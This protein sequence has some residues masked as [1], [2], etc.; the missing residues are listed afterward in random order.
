MGKRS[1]LTPAFSKKQF[2]KAS[3][4]LGVSVAALREAFNKAPQ[5]PVGSLERPPPSAQPCYEARDNGGRC[6][7]PNCIYS[8]D[9]EV[10]R[11]ARAEKKLKDKGK[12]KDNDK[13]KGK[14]K[15]KDKGGKAKG[16]GRGD[17]QPKPKGKAKW[18]S[19]EN[20]GW[21]SGQKP[22]CFKWMSAPAL[23]APL[24]AISATLSRWSTRSRKH[25]RKRRSTR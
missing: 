4:S 9:P 10:L 20:N 24:S 7:R 17:G 15:G 3:I 22:L 11:K 14:G 21:T 19:E 25:S 1:A 13:G 8:H 23:K 5:N 12:G 2:K 18:Q 6:T 16:K